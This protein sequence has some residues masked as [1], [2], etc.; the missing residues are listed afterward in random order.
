[1][2]AQADADLHGRTALEHVD[3]EPPRG[4]GAVTKYCYGGTENN[5]FYGHGEI[6]ALRALSD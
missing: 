3:Q 6:N 2:G 1:L 5:G 4:G